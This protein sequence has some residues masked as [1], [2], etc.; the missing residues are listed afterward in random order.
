MY[1]VDVDGVECVLSVENVMV[2]YFVKLCKSKAYWDERGMVVLLLS[3]FM[4][5]CFGCVG[6]GCEVKM[7]FVVDW[8]E[9]L[10][11]I[12]V[13]RVIRASASVLKKCAGVNNVDGLDVVG[14]F[15]LLV[16]MNVCEF[17]D[18]VK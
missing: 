12:W 9:V 16:I 6:E 1:V 8:V 18:G 2:K 15:V 11:G 10:V 3:V 14:E 7:L 17:V 13:K 5:E 4:C